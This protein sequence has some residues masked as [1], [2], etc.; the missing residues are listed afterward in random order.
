MTYTQQDSGFAAR[1]TLDGDHDGPFTAEAVVRRLIDEAFGQGHLEVCDELIADEIVEHQ[2]YGPGH[3]AGAAGVKAVVT[4]LRRAFSDFK[5]EIE[6]LVVAGDTVWTRNVATGTNDGPYMGHP[7]SGRAFRVYVFRC[8]ARRP[9]PRRRALGRPGSCG[10]A[11]PARRDRS[12]IEARQGSVAT[13]GRGRFVRLST[14]G[15]LFIGREPAATIHAYNPPSASTPV[16]GRR[17]R[18]V[19]PGAVTGRH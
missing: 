14:S 4:S 9:R 5:L 2:D 8:D 1:E 13:S 12:A 16:T 10:R 18:L 19:V 11:R 15:A 7:P 3:A 17:F 6:D